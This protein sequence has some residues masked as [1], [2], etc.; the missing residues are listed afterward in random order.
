MGQQGHYPFGESWYST[1]TTTKWQFTTYER[2]SESGL[3]YAMFR[4][5]SSRLGR[6]MTPDPFGG[7]LGDPQSL[8]RY[9]YTR[10]DPVNLADPLGLTFTEWW[11]E[12]SGGSGGGWYVS[13]WSGCYDA[14]CTRSGAESRWRAPDYEHPSRR[15]QVDPFCLANPPGPFASPVAQI[16]CDDQGCM[17]GSYV[18]SQYT[19][20]GGYIVNWAAQREAQIRRAVNK[21]VAQLAANATAQE[22]VDFLLK[23]FGLDKFVVPGLK[24]WKG[25]GYILQFTQAVKAYLESLVATG[26]FAKGDLGVLHKGDVGGTIDKDYRSFTGQRTGQDSSLQAVLGVKLGNGN[27]LAWVDNDKCNVYQDLVGAMCHLGELIGGIF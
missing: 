19:A 26:K 8:N 11:E 21:F 13:I 14:S 5:D 24:E 15:C 18:Y 17:T 10:N 1:S 22:R 25:N 9:V 27:Y 3:D 23:F 16:H 4:Y 20:G 6:F 7:S 2:D 12:E